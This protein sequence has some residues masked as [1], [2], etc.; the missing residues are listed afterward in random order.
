MTNTFIFFAFEV[1]FLMRLLFEKGYFREV[2]A[3][4]M[5]EGRLYH[6]FWAIPLILFS[7]LFCYALGGVSLSLIIL[8]CSVALLMFYL[9]NRERE[10]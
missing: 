3:S 9:C 5:A 1:D 7:G 8:G 4:A 2:A 6:F 10:A